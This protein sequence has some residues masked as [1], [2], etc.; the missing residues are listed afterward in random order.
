[1]VAPGCWVEEIVANIYKETK[2]GSKVLPEGL[3]PK[4]DTKP[5][6]R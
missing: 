1:M 2:E 3:I 5:A 4:E 6:G